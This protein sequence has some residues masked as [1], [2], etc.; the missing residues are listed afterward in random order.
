MTVAIVAFLHFVRHA[1]RYIPSRYSQRPG[2]MDR[3]RNAVYILCKMICLIMLY[4]LGEHYLNEWTV[5][6]TK[7]VALWEEHRLY[8]EKNTYCHGVL[9]LLLC[10]LGDRV[11]LPVLAVTV[12][13]ATS[14]ARGGWVTGNA[15]IDLHTTLFH[16]IYCVAI[17]T[18]LVRR[19]SQLETRVTRFA[20][21]QLENQIRALQDSMQRGSEL[22]IQEQMDN[23]LHRERVAELQ[24]LES[25]A[26]HRIEE[27]NAELIRCK[28]DLICL[29][30]PPPSS[31]ATPSPSYEPSV[32]FSTIERK[33]TAHSFA[34]GPSHDAEGWRVTTS[35]ASSLS[36]DPE[37]PKLGQ[38]IRDAA[39]QNRLCDLQEQQYSTMDRVNCLLERVGDLEHSVATLSTYRREGDR[40]IASITDRLNRTNEYAKQ[41][42]VS[43]MAAGKAVEDRVGVVEQ[44]VKDIYAYADHASTAFTDVRDITQANT[45]RME[46]LFSV[47]GILAAAHSPAIGETR[48]SSPPS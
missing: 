25:C 12:W 21:E 24:H 43:V 48:P 36:Y 15:H 20:M 18:R 14:Y 1:T 44:E 33:D 5:R 45:K 23:A 42:F 39:P 41:G 37:D 2:V 30:S 26:R 9:A 46:S 22:L 27:L 3:L 47:M 11:P 10:A 32:D 34:S 40:N 29:R 8:A 35:Y 17:Y 6:R 19:P 31:C 7:L 28:A 38:A 16:G 4:R 13:F